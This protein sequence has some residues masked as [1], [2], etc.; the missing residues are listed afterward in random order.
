MDGREEEY[1]LAGPYLY[2]R[3]VFVVKKDS[4][5]RELSDLVG[6][7]IAL[8]A[9]LT[10]ENIILRESDPDIPELTDI[11]TFR[12]MGEVFTN[13]RKGYAD[14]IVGHEAALLIYTREYGDEY[15]YLPMTVHRGKLGVAFSKSADPA[16]CESLSQALQEMTKDGTTGR[17]MVGC[18]ELETKGEMAVF[19]LRCEDTG[20]GMSKEF[21]K[22]AFELFAQEQDDAR[23]SYEGTGLGLAI[24]KNW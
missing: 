17:I 24:V 5:I 21:Q 20:I 3:R 9:G 19:E 23:T 1:Q 6:K 22:H 15:R 2:T 11:N 16:V 8:Q 18:R 14:A 4:D 13:L 10:S 7:T 12:T